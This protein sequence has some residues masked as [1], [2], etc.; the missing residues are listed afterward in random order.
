MTKSQPKSD[1]PG[2]PVFGG[3]CVG[4]AVAARTCLGG[5]HKLAKLFTFS[6]LSSNVKVASQ[7]SDRPCYGRS[8][9]CSVRFAKQPGP[10]Q[11]VA[12]VENSVPAGGLTVPVRARFWEL[13]IVAKPCV[14]SMLSSNAKGGSREP[15]LPCYGPPQRRLVSFRKR[16]GSSSRAASGA[17]WGGK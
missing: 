17:A 9:Q 3:V 13:V 1:P 12:F 4:P 15:D 16:I 14:F 2:I 8:R 11:A 6:M 7:E 5:G 10:D